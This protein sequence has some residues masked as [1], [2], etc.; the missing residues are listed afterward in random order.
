MRLA[1]WTAALRQEFGLP[2]VLSVALHGLVGLALSAFTLSTQ[3]MPTQPEELRVDLV[4]LE[5]ASPARQTAPARKAQPVHVRTFAP[6]DPTQA[7]PAQPIASSAALAPVAPN[8]PVEQGAEPP[9]SFRDLPLVLA[10]AAPPAVAFPETVA[11]SAPQPEEPPPSVS[12][13][14][15]AMSLSRPL[16]ITTSGSARLLRDTTAEAASTRSKVRFGYNQRPEYP[17][18]AREAGWEGTTVLQI[19][20]LPDGT[21][22]SLTLLKTSGHAVLDEAALASVKTWR[23]IPARDG[24]FP[25]RSVVRLP[26]RFDLK[27]AG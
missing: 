8:Q 18:A 21:V 19:V 1:T 25:I 23:F 12:E 5:P 20:V 15:E 16:P 9:P 3:V 27:E 14:T 10:P 11:F 2:A 7:A 6:R 4:S 13:S 26:I 24:N 22:G 17:R